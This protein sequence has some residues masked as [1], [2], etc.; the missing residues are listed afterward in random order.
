[1]KIEVKVEVEAPNGAT[2]YFGEL[3]DDPLWFKKKYIAGYAHWFGLTRSGEWVLV[4]HG[5]EAPRWSKPL[6]PKT[7][8]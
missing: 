8:G 4:R 5:E 3:L 1:M 2:H 6:N 7:D